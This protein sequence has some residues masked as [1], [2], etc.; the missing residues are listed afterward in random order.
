MLQIEL[1]ISFDGSKIEKLI[2]LNDRKVSVEKVQ[3][4]LSNAQ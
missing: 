2:Q 1:N 4:V 3:T